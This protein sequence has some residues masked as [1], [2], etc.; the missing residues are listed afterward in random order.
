MSDIKK[1][2]I[3]FLGQK[4][5]VIGLSE[6]A[7]LHSC[8]CDKLNFILTFWLINFMK[9]MVYLNVKLENSCKGNEI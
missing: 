2:Q 6:V 5:K 3:D 7:M 4:I 9:L 1:R 8:A